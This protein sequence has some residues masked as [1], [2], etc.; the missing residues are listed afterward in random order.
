[1]K[2][3]NYLKYIFLILLLI[4][5]QV[6]AVWPNPPPAGATCPQLQADC[7]ASMAALSQG[8]VFRGDCTPQAWAGSN[9]ERE[10]SFQCQWAEQ[11]NAWISCYRYICTVPTCP[12]GQVLAESGTGC[13]F[14]PNPNPMP[15]APPPTSPHYCEAPLILVP[16][17]VICE[18]PVVCTSPQV[19]N[20]NTN[21]C[22]SPPPASCNTAAAACQTAIAGHPEMSCSVDVARAIS[23]M[24]S[25]QNSRVICTPCGGGD[26]YEADA[27]G[28]PINPTNPTNPTDP[29]N[30]TAD[31]PGLETRKTNCEGNGGQWSSSPAV[32]ATATAAAVP[33][34]WT[35]KTSTKTETYDST[36]RI[37]VPPS[38]TPKPQELNCGG[39]TGIACESTQLSS[40]SKLTDIAKFLGFDATKPLFDQTKLQQIQ[41]DISEISGKVL[42][43]DDVPEVKTFFGAIAKVT[44]TGCYGVKF[45][46]DHTMG[47]DFTEFNK[48]TCDFI[49]VIRAFLI[50]TT[51]M[52]AAV[53]IAKD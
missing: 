14:P 34:T 39:T 30:P 21:A 37:Y 40:L 49:A 33:E 48:V 9:S 29:T 32:P 53:F 15:T 52:Q 41:K 45:M 5:Q 13:T 44:V 24:S 18:L 11:N 22:T 28:N 47:L 12:E 27:A 42:T 1:M 4:S 6:Y 17:K 2:N 46:P 26:P 7:T 10:I 16:S 19:R 35:C 31:A 20:E 43:L 8:R 51:L 50:A 3:F 36:G 25:S 38:S 23:C